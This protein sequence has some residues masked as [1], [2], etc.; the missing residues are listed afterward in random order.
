[1]VGEM[2]EQH[3]KALEHITQAQTYERQG[4][5]VQAIALYL[6]AGDEAVRGRLFDDPE[7]NVFPQIFNGLEGQMQKIWQGYELKVQTEIDEKR[8]LRQVEGTNPPVYQVE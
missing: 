3:Q 1:M 2:Q 6:R 8:G 5:E 7:F 4:K